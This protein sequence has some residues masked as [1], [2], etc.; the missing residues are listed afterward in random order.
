MGTAFAQDA[1]QGN[2]F[3]KLVRYE[4]HLLRKVQTAEK[5]LARLQ[6]CRKGAPPVAVVKPRNQ[7][8]KPDRSAQNAGAIDNGKPLD[9]DVQIHRVRN[10]LM[11]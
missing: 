2:S 5:E 3:S 6:A 8:A 9:A 11:L 4:A 10:W 1:T 7:P